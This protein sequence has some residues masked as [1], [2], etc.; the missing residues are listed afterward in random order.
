MK[1]VGQPLLTSIV[2]PIFKGMIQSI[3]SKFIVTRK[4]SRQFMKQYVC[5][6]YCVATIVTSKLP[7]T[8][9]RDKIKLFFYGCSQQVLMECSM[10]SPNKQPYKLWCSFE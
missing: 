5:W 9:I 3:V 6:T 8:I 4:W 7:L 2:Q 1:E 10:L